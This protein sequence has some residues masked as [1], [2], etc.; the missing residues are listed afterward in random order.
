MEN[1]IL[2]I[3]EVSDVM[4]SDAL[5]KTLYSNIIESVD[6]NSLIEEI[7]LDIIFSFLDD[8]NSSST[9]KRLSNIPDIENKFLNSFQNIEA[10]QKFTS[11]YSEL[12]NIF[13][14]MK[15]DVEYDYFIENTKIRISE[16]DIR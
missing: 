15:S 2:P 10:F 13:G 12:Y 11:V 1:I 5:D 16:N 14:Q 7:N 3:E 6:E 9:T 8:I 4:P